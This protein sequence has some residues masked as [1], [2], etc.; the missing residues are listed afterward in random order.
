MIEKGPSYADLCAGEIPGNITE[1]VLQKGNSQ[2]SISPIGATITSWHV[3]DRSLIT[4]PRVKL[5]PE[6]SRD[7]F[8]GSIPI[9]F[10]ICGSPGDGDLSKKLP[11]HGFARNEIWERVALQDDDSNGSIATFR[12]TANERTRETYPFDFEILNT[13]TLGD[14]SLRYDIQICNRGNQSTGEMLLIQMKP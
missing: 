3:G 4:A 2:L 14:K 13:I 12:L 5:M 7:V 6:E 1:T 10:P 9:L 11:Q 8:R